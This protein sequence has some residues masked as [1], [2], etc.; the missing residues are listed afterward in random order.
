M[1]IPGESAMTAAI[2]VRT[3]NG[4]IIFAGFY[5]RSERSAR[6][7]GLGALREIVFYEAPHRIKQSLWM[8]GSLPTLVV[9]AS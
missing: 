4:S 1:P 3:L 5:R 9:R 8:P 6:R 7:Q 2:A